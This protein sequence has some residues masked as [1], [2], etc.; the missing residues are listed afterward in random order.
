MSDPKPYEIT[1][2]DRTDY[3][4]T[5]VVVHQIDEKMYSSCVTLIVNA[6]RKA[7]RDRLLIERDIQGVVPKAVVLLQVRFLHEISEGLKV[8][9]VDANRANVAEL[10]RNISLLGPN[11]E[12]MRIF[13]DQDAAESWLAD[14]LGAM[15][16]T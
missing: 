12:N 10:E 2:D 11:E 8:A 4:Y 16:R 14:D 15:I 3:F 9:I 6:C 7:G 1:F 13:S 5:H